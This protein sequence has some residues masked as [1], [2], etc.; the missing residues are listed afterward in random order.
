MK[1][2]AIIVLAALTA[3]AYAPCAYARPAGTVVVRNVVVDYS[4]LNL[5]TE[6]G[7]ATLHERI[8]QAAAQACGGNPIFFT[9]YR[10][11]PAYESRIFEACRAKAMDGALSEVRKH[12]AVR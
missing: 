4:D 10:D 3:T 12:N 8:A 6:L 11:A 7:A 1:R 5:A 2:S 9:N